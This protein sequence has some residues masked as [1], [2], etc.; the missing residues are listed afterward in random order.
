MLLARNYI[1]EI[2]DAFL[3]GVHLCYDATQKHIS[4]CCEQPPKGR[5]TWSPFQELVQE[6]N[7]TLLPTMR[8]N[9]KTSPWIL[10]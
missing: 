3:D 8:P 10:T 6:H 9:K 5:E 7:E 4:W 2:V 1:M